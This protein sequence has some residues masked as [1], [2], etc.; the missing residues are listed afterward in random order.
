MPEYN[1]N[2]IGTA[3]F[4]NKTSVDPEFD[5]HE[6]RFDKH[7][8]SAPYGD[9]TQYGSGATGGAGAGNKLSSVTS[10]DEDDSYNNTDLRTNTHHN[11]DPYSGHSGYGSG[12]TGGAGF[13]NKTQ[14]EYSDSRRGKIM[15]KLGGMMGKDDIA[16]KGHAK[17]T[18]AGYEG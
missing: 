13:G 5:G 7:H 1:A 15:E 9:A 11:T 14:G 8:D 2:N 4:G 12:T 6:T 18:E 17:R 16:E 10:G 3:G